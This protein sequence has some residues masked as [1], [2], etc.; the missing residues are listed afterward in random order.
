LYK[1]TNKQT[2]KQT[3][4]LG[5]FTSD[6]K[7]WKWNAEFSRKS[8][9][10]NWMVLLLSVPPV[11]CSVTFLYR[12]CAV[13]S[14]FCTGCALFCHI[15]VPAVRC[16][17]TFLYRLYAVL[18]HFSTVRVFFSLIKR[19]TE[20]VD[21]FLTDI[22]FCG[23][24]EIWQNICV[25]VCVRVS[26]S[27]QYLCVR[28]CQCEWAIFVCA[29]VSVRVSNICVCVRVSASERYLCVR[30]CQCEWAI[31]VCACVS[32]RVSNIC[33]CVSVRVRNYTVVVVVVVV[34]VVTHLVTSQKTTETLFMLIPF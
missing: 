3:Q 6:L 2:N 27:E 23:R 31:F 15:S 19:V 25:C 18:S 13:L 8:E 10:H 12:L 4:T 20:N 28:A 22:D 11:R 29:C 7:P 33:V 21:S 17:V 24:R 26:A 34:V 5:I 1:Q 30:A 16:S 14:H 32:V 9:T